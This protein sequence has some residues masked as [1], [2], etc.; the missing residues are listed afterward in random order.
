MPR[1]YTEIRIAH[2]S[3]ERKKQFEA[4]LDETVKRERYKNRADWVYYKAQE[5][6]VNENI[7]SLKKSE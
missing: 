3:E 5:A 6:W 7:K 1:I 4:E 2:E